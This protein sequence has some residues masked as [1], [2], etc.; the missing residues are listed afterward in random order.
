MEFWFF[1]NWNFRLEKKSSGTGYSNNPE[2]INRGIG[3]YTGRLS[4]VACQQC[5][6]GST[7][8]PPTMLPPSHVKYIMV[9]C[10]IAA[11]I[12]RDQTNCQHDFC[13]PKLKLLET[14]FRI[15]E[16]TLECFSRVFPQEKNEKKFKSLQENALKMDE[17]IS[18]WQQKNQAENWFGQ[19][20]SAP[21]CNSYLCWIFGQ[22]IGPCSA[23]LLLSRLRHTVVPNA[24]NSPKI[25]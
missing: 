7:T 9:I 19:A 10:C 3:C 13:C 4:M 20:W 11:W 25:S 14:I 21:V 16:K 8:E 2:Q 15:F 12:L 1:Q 22:A 6:L 24:R 5:N 18:I 17:R 23:Q